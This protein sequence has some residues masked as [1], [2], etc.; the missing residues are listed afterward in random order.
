[1]SRLDDL[2]EL[3]GEIDGHAAVT[4]ELL[5]A[6]QTLVIDDIPRIG[7]NTI[8]SVA[9]AGSSKCPRFGPS[10]RERVR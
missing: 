8:T 6:V 4:G 10:C 1:M 7:R 2:R 9:A 3:I 5:A